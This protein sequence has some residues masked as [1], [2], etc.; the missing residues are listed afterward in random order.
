MDEDEGRPRDFED[1]PGYGDL[2][3]PEV[4]FVYYNL[5]EKKA[6][7]GSANGEKMPEKRLIEFLPLSKVDEWRKKLDDKWEGFSLM[8][9]GH[10]WYSVEHY[11]CGAKYKK[12]YPD[13]YMQFSL[14]SGSELSRNVKMIKTVKLKT[15]DGKVPKVDADYPLGREVEE[16]KLAL[17]QKFKQ[18][19][20]KALLKM[21]KNALLLRKDHKGAIAEP[22]IELMRIRS[23]ET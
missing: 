17:E 13:V 9:D 7:P 5:A 16:R 14:D 11:V 22:D 15:S 2:Y 3:D 12:G 6:K 1:E 19:D 23:R 21:T 8:V 20:M 4:V 10:K 18:E